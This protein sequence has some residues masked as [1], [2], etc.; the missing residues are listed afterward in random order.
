MT[1]YAQDQMVKADDDYT[2]A[3]VTGI[4]ATPKTDFVKGVVYHADDFAFSSDYDDDGQQEFTD[5][6]DDDVTFEPETAEAA[7]K[8]KVTISFKDSGKYKGYDPIETTIN[9]IDPEDGEVSLETDKHI[10]INLEC[11]DLL[12]KYMIHF[13][14]TDEKGNF[15][16][17]ATFALKA[18]CE[19]VDKNGK[20]IFH[21]GDTITTTVSQDDQFG[22]VEFFG[23]P[24]GIYAKDGVGKQMYTVEE[25]TPPVG[26]EK[27]DKVLTFSGEVLN[28]KTENLIHDVAS[29]GN[30]NDEEN[31]YQHDSDTF[32]NK[33]SDYVQVKKYWIDDDNSMNTRPVSVT[34]KAEHK[35]T[36]EVKTY[37]LNKDNNWAIQTD[38]KR[39]EEGNYTFSE[40]CNAAGYERVDKYSTGTWDKN[41]YTLSYTNKYD[42]GG[43][44]K[45]VVKK[46]WDDSNNSD[47]IRPDSVVVRIYQNGT[48]INHKTLDAEQ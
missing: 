4:S 5:V 48:E 42:K 31:T 34:I 23:L 35:T 29:E 3:K 9:V 13:I 40:V 32:V 22:Y 25:I 19:I 33:K 2:D 8:Q 1:T 14:K 15:L 16:P 21:K 36:H 27:T 28:D 24:T 20:T 41:T 12:Q 45:L 38:I 43:S 37:V 10:N 6:T 11:N 7:G 39:G 18:A 46:N 17:G 47:G 30:T 44:V 26:Y